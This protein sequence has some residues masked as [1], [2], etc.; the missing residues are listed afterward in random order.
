METRAKATRAPRV[1]SGV[2]KLCPTANRWYSNGW[3][4]GSRVPVRHYHPWR[5]E[6]SRGEDESG[7]AAV[8]GLSYPQ[9]RRSRYMPHTACSR[10][11]AGWDKTESITAYPLVVHFL[12]IL[13]IRQ[14]P[15]AAEGFS[16][17]NPGPA[18]AGS[19][20]PPVA[21]NV[22]LQAS[23]T[24]SVLTGGRGHT[25]GLLEAASALAHCKPE[26]GESLPQEGSR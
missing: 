14:V 5:L 25:R 19:G 8:Q 11:Q 4:S 18:P 16:F 15:R 23:G 22:S 26:D 2:D 3:S 6:V 10:P 12:P 9:G 1:L 21:M 24:V 13:P 20:G 17:A 7:V